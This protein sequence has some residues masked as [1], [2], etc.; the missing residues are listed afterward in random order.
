MCSCQGKTLF[1]KA[2]AT[3]TN[4]CFISV[5]PEDILNDLISGSE[6]RM[7]AVFDIACAKAVESQH[8][9]ILF[10]DEVD[11]ILGKPGHNDCKAKKNVIK[12]FQTCIDGVRKCEGDVLVLAATNYRNDLPQAVLSRFGTQN[13]VRLPSAGELIKIMKLHMRKREAS[14]DLTDGEYQNLAEK[15]EEEG[16]SGCDVKHLVRNTVNTLSIQTEESEYWCRDDGGYYV[17]CIHDDMSN[18]GR[19]KRS[20]DEVADEAQLPPLSY[21]HFEEAID[22][23]GISSIGQ[24]DL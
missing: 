9:T 13:H 23:Y 5:S 16:A 17:P 7:R 15:M 24:E 20:L 2:L 3:A 8:P 19:E 12:I 11:G 4:G 6:K 1:A 21:R 18:C 22:A 14:T 10:L